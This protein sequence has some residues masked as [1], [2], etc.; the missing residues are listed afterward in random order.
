MVSECS[1]AC[2]FITIAIYDLNCSG[3]P[4]MPFVKCL[5]GVAEVP[6]Q[7]PPLSLPPPNAPRMPKNISKKNVPGASPE[8][9]LV[10]QGSC[11]EVLPSACRG[12]VAGRAPFP[13]K[14]FENVLGT[15]CEGTFEWRARLQNTELR[16]AMRIKIHWQFEALG[17]SAHSLPRSQPWRT[18]RFLL[19]FACAF[20]T[21]IC[22]LL[23][24]QFLSF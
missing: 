17:V 8:G 16:V 19:A 9:T 10:L 23:S 5:S 3:F 2:D 21:S 12:T 14:W 24:G 22:Y 1:K 11:C 4:N 7:V 6:C 15:R 13:S 20:A 18:L